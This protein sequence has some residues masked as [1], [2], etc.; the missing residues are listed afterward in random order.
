MNKSTHFKCL[1]CKLEFAHSRPLCRKFC[2]M[3]SKEKNR[4][5]NKKKYDLL[6]PN[7]SHKCK[8]CDVIIPDNSKKIC[9]TCKAQAKC[10]RN[11]K[12]FV[13][14]KVVVKPKHPEDFT[15]ELLGC[16]L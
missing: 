3:C 1:E 6:N 14:K 15:Y 4:A 7:R 13:K 16:P 9:D 8:T 12:N 10:N 5:L 11:L 2:V